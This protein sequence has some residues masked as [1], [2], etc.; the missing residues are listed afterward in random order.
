MA[1][2]AHI[3]VGGGCGFLGDEAFG[4]PYSQ[5][6]LELER[7]CV[8]GY[9]PMEVISMATK[10]NAKLLLMEDELGTLEPGKLADVLLVSGNPG[11]DIQVL[12]HQDNV[13]L[14][15]QDGRVV[16]NALDRINTK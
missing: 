13:K 7:L 16:K 5:A 8:A 4:C 10:T 14:V 11:A 2:K 12:R 3:Q 9:T 15:I 6:T 1:R